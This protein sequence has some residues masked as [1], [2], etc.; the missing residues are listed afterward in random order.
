[1][2]RGH[3][4]GDRLA[5]R[6][7]SAGDQTIEAVFDEQQGTVRIEATPIGA[8][9]FRTALDE[10]DQIPLVAPTVRQVSVQFGSA[11]K[12]AEDL[13]SLLQMLS[14]VN[15]R[16][17]AEVSAVEAL[18]A[19]LLTGSPDSVAEAEALLGRVDLPKA[20]AQVVRTVSVQ[21]VADP[22]QLLEDAQELFE[23]LSTGSNLP[24]SITAT[25]KEEAEVVLF[26]GSLQ[27][28]QRM[29][30]AMAQARAA[31]PAPDVRRVVA[32]Q[33]GDA[34]QVA[35]RLRTALDEYP[36]E[37][38]QSMDPVD[39]SVLSITNELVLIGPEQWVQTGISLLAKVDRLGDG[40]L[41]PLRLLGVRNTDAATVADLLRR[42]FDARGADE[43]RSDPVEIDVAE[44]ANVLIIT[45]SDDRQTEIKGLVDELN[46]FGGADREGRVI[47]IFPLKTAQAE[48]LART[49]DE[50]FPEKPV[51]L[52]RRGRPMT[53]LREPR[54][55][56]VRA[57]R[58]TN[59][60]I[61]DALADRMS[62]F[63]ELVRQL[64]REQVRTETSIRTYRLTEADPQRSR[65]H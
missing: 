63:E 60:L 14:D 2:E 56:V 18:N 30:E 8:D 39:V 64:D 41:P 48:E 16:R 26:S 21:N 5:S 61:V 22:E 27:A 3:W 58:Q 19:L 51:P 31:L 15:G 7:L 23:I 45:A 25:Y 20:G 1:M 12:V 59:S 65:R 33:R 35:E 13:T 6:A 55:V 46:A 29:E 54:D 11:A 50:M 38:G 37:P 10:L 47:R 49:L 42:R 57:N 4:P 32:V 9:T 53:E 17:A 62:S 36:K 52:D 24:A 40:P 34:E 28:V 44:G 43:R